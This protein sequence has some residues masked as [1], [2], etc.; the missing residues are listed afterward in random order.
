M[1]IIKSPSFALLLALGI[2]GCGG[3]SDSPTNTDDDQGNVSDEASFSSKSTNMALFGVDTG[4]A[5]IAE[6]TSD[7]TSAIVLDDTNTGYSGFGISPGEVPVAPKATTQN[8]ITDTNLTNATNDLIAKLEAALND[9]GA[10]ILASSNILVNKII[11]GPRGYIANVTADLDL[12]SIQKTSYIRNLLLNGFGDTDFGASDQ[13]QTTSDSYR[14]NLAIWIVDNIIYNWTAIYSEDNAEA[15]GAKYGDINNGTS[16]TNNTG[17]VAS[18][19]DAF[20]QT[21][22]SNDADILWVIDNSGSMS[23]EQ[24]NI[25]SGA[26]QFFDT[27]NSANVNYHLA[28]ATTEYSSRLGECF[29]LSSLTDETSRWI[30]PTTPDA[31][32]EW[33]N[34]AKPGTNGGTETGLFCGDQAL[35]DPTNTN[36]GFD[37][38]GAPNIIVMLSDEP[39]NETLHGY[40]PRQNTVQN[41]QN[42]DLAAYVSAY[43]QRQD[44]VF[45]IVGEETATDA[46]YPAGCR[47]EGGSAEGGAHYGEVAR[48]TG[49]SRASICANADSWQVM[50]NEIAS[51]ASGLASQF[52]LTE[53]PIASTVVVKVNG[54]AVPRATENGFGLVYANDATRVVFYGTA[55]PASGDSVQ[56]SYDYLDQAS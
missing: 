52:V 15:V 56:I 47:G 24:S 36:A 50:F 48:A 12:R 13:V 26:T 17:E 46:I 2:S 5:T 53:V 30:T 33:T 55:V 1:N 18:N 41:Y 11:Q 14:V 54:T 51:T 44:T 3:G 31:E 19:A 9:D 39:D 35:T 42:R 34:I 22:G 6:T 43:Q 38:A 20:T 4:S 28:V 45:A 32:T 10:G 16:V 23:E 21:E 37:R 27:L 7:N 40:S 25:A 8:A 49:G 29:E